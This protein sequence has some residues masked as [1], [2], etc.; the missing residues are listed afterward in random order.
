MTRTHHRLVVIGAGPAGYTAAIYASRAGLTPLVLEGGQPGGQLTITTEIENFPGFR[1]GIPGPDLM[2][3]M[4]EQALRFGTEIKAEAAISVNLTARPFQVTTDQGEYTAEA[5]IIATGA[6]ARWLGLG[7]DQELSRSGGGVSACATCDGFFFRGK[8]IAVV[9][10]GD[11]ALEEATYLTRFARRVHL[12]HRRDAFRASKA[13]QERSL[14]HEKIQVHWNKVVV[15]ITTQAKATP[16]GVSVERI[17]A[18]V[19]ED[20]AGGG[21]SE[22]SVEG[23]FVAIGHQPN[24][25]LF[26]GQLPMDENGYLQVEKG[27]ARTAIPGVFAAGDVADPT[28]RQAIT[29]AGSGCM[30]A[31]DAERWLAANEAW[32]E[33][34]CPT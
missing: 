31:L 26:A 9:G 32:M 22:L 23:L 14:A 21:R 5:V 18:L 7:K 3:E 34:P 19:L 28:Y 17:Q 16:L 20:T 4:R 12:I 25:S 10:G 1:Q 24:T 8:E 13:M 15:D 11:T 33:V 6:S 27:T 29:A 2:T 30:A